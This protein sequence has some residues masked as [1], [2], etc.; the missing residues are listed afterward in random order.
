MLIKEIKEE[1]NFIKK[2]TLQPAWW[3]ITKIFILL[4]SLIIIFYIFGLLKTII[5]FSIVIILG[6]IIHFIY[7]IKTHIYTK[8]WMDFKVIEKEG[9]LTYGRIGFL[10]YTL[11]III[12]SIATIIILLV[13]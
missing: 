8:S 13:Q 1:V 5:W 6:V 4:G 3:K 10:Y 12:F 7:R 2:H 11:V 9:K